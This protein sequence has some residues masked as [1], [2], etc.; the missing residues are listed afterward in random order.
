MQVKNRNIVFQA[1][2]YPSSTARTIAS[3]ASGRTWPISRTMA[4]PTIVASGR[5]RP[6]PRAPGPSRR[7]I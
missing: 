7:L 2:T 5:I 4:A 6:I 1:E 3:V